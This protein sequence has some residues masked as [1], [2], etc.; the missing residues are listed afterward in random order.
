MKNK[1]LTLF[2][3]LRATSEDAINLTIQS[4]KAYGSQYKHWAIS[5]SGGKDSTTVVTLILY[6]IDSG[7]IDPPESLTVLYADTRLELPPLQISA[8]QILEEV[9]RRGFNAEVVTAE[10]DKRFLVYLLGRGV[11]P[12]NN[13]TM[14]WCTQQIKLTPM[15]AAMQRLYAQHGE[16]F[17]SLNGVRIGES[18]IRDARIVMSCSKNGSECGQGW[19]QRDI[20]DSVCDK[21]APILHWRVCSVWD[22]LM[23]DAPRL[24]LDTAIL[25]EAYGGDEATELNARTG[26]IGCPLASQDTALLYLIKQPNW[27]YLKPLLQIRS[28]W[29]EA[30]KFNHR[31]QKAEP[32]QLK[33]GGFSKNP[34]RKGPLTLES[35]K[36]FLAQILAIQSE[37][38]QQAGKLGRPKI[39]ILN[40]EE[41]DRINELIELKTFPNKW[42]GDEPV[43][44][45]LIPQYYADGSVQPLLW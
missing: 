7:K 11:P 20:P 31:L 28:I 26:C 40:Q 22:W 5:F 2:D 29:E 41:I 38:N 6:L 23:I 39:D 19:F 35:R 21:L 15:I 24:G 30:R 42:T 18:A 12:P 44:S 8:M 25:A 27:A 14:R 1:Q 13:N 45:L 16:R 10:M 34:N 33:N 43:G 4:L 32:E 9:K 36:A 37:V 3:N 17:L